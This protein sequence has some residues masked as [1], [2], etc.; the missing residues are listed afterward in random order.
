MIKYKILLLTFICFIFGFVEAYAEQPSSS[1][2][3]REKS[4][5]EAGELSSVIVVTA[6]NNESFDY[7]LSNSDSC[8]NEDCYPFLTIKPNFPLDSSS[9]TRMLNYLK[10]LLPVYSEM[11]DLDIDMIEI[12]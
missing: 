3:P 10:Q 4:Q 11:D 5:V 7:G 6:N 9:N 8:L 1:N 12:L 2:P